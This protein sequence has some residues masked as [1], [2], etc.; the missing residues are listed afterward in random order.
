MSMIGNMPKHIKYLG[1]LSLLA[2]VLPARA[3]ERSMVPFVIPWTPNPNS[4]VAYPASPAILPNSNRVVVANAHFS[5]DGKPIR[6]WSIN[7]TFNACFPAHA[8]AEVLALR[9]SQAGINCVRLHHMDFSTWPRG[10]FDEKEP[11]QLSA[12]AI[13]RLDFLL[14]ALA[15]HGV[16]A[17][18]NLHVSSVHSRYIDLPPVPGVSYD[19]MTD[20]FMPQLIDA[21]KDYARQLLGHVNGYRK[22]RYADDPEIAL[23]EINNEDSLFMWGSAE[24]LPNLPEP[25]ASTLQSQYDGWL[26]Q[27]YTTSDKLRAAWAKDAEPLGDDLLSLPSEAT[28]KND[29]WSLEVHP[30]NSAKIV[31]PADGSGYRV[32]IDRSDETNWHLQFEHGDLSV[33]AGKYYTVQFTA[34]ADRPRSVTYGIGQ[35]HEP[36]NNLG[37]SS[38]AALTPKWKTFRKGFV[39]SATEDGARLCFLVGASNTAIEL[40]DISLCAGGRD[41]LTADESLEAGNISV[42]G[43]GNTEARSS[44]SLRFLA[45]TEKSFF[46]GMY[47]YV[48][49]DLGCTALVTGTIV[50]GPL[51]LYGQSDM[52]FVDAHA[53]WNHPEFPGRSWDPVNWNVE[54]TAA[55]DRPEKSTLIEL[56]SERLAGKPFTV[57]EYCEPA[58]NDFQSEEVPEIASFAAAQDF[59]GVWLFDYGAVPTPD[60]FENFF[61]HGGNPSK[62]GFMSAAAAIYRGGAIQPLAGSKTISLV[63]PNDD[64]RLLCSLQSKYNLNLYPALEEVANIKWPDYLNDQMRVTFE[65]FPLIAEAPPSATH[66]TNEMTGKQGTYSGSSTGA[67]V[68]IGRTTG[69]NPTFASIIATAMDGQPFSQTHRILIATCGQ[70][71]NS[72]MM[73]TPD[74]KSVGQHWGHGPVNIETIDGSITFPSTISAGTWTL[75]PVGPDG[76]AM[77]QSRQVEIDPGKPISLKADDR[78][79]WILLTR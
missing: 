11:T 73:F 24:H 12:E 9:L 77:G 2:M 10:I 29:P 58:P 30:G 48:K 14:D 68:W 16:Y 25:Y 44:D 34:R 67:I 60:H 41:G 5:V 8:D 72:G 42:F 63:S 7:L 52:D 26:K 27:R 66:F 15:R 57:T 19:K 56:A 53:Y 45:I 65:K 62:W 61:D 46:D 28:P 6:F 51:G 76:N 50:F 21:Q 32:E 35:Q 43:G 70:C 31:K 71:E 64:M 36:W 4:L 49:K 78:T 59:D 74:H 47:H 75:Q 20:L 3:A 13:D 1:L 79:M 23:V 33:Q 54:Q 22:L 38:A 40:K 37:L 39:A 18:L 55:V 17:D 69:A